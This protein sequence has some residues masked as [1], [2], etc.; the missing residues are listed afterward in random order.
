MGLSVYKKDTYSVSFNG[1]I[2][3]SVLEAVPSVRNPANR[4]QPSSLEEGCPVDLR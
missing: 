1:F 2:S 3:A 4:K